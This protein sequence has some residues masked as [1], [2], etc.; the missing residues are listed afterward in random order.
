MRVSGY[1]TI[2]LNMKYFLP[3]ENR[4][5]EYKINI[6]WG[7][8]TAIHFVPK[9]ILLEIDYASRV[10]RT[11]TVLEYILELWEPV[12]NEQH[13]K[14]NLIGKSFIAG[15]G[16]QKT[17]QIADVIFHESPATKT[18]LWRGKKTDLVTYY[19][20]HYKRNIQAENNQPLLLN[21][22]VKKERDRKTG[23]SK[24]VEQNERFFVPELC[25]MTGIPEQMTKDRKVMQALDTFTKLTPNKRLRK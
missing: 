25:L 1:G 16:N 2:G 5:P 17:Y 4:I 23:R 15:Y 6:W 3:D 22:E 18:F 14:D 10:L 20:E 11:Q 9:R 24:I 13:I 12:K 19:R 8:K 21:Y 7:F